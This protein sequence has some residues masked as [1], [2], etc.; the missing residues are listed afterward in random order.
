MK[1]TVVSA[2]GCGQTF[3]MKFLNENNI[4]TNCLLDTDNIKHCSHPK[5]VFDKSKTT[6]K[7][8]FLYNNPFLTILSHFRRN[9]HWTQMHKLGSPYKIN[10]KKI[11]SIKDFINLTKQYGH[12]IFGIKYQFDNWINY[13]KS[14]SILFLD[15]TTIEKNQDILNEF[16]G[17][18]LNFNNFK[19]IKR[20]SCPDN[21]DSCIIKIY[22]DLY[23]YIKQKV[24]ERNNL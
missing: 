21:Y 4:E 3:F 9:W 13:D 20:N 2:G 24:S 7:V 8:I 18:K 1:I 5:F 11:T 17:E 19:I 23:T 10:Y 22:E 15:F 12:D 6:E 14:K 16:I